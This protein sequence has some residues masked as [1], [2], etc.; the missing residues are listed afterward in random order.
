MKA[1][2]KR[3]LHTYGFAFVQYVSCALRRRDL[4]LHFLS[5]YCYTESSMH[6]NYHP[7]PFRDITHICSLCFH[8]TLPFQKCMVIVMYQYELISVSSCLC[9]AIFL[10]QLNEHFL[11]TQTFFIYPPSRYRCTKNIQN[12]SHSQASLNLDSQTLLCCESLALKAE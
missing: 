11:T 10:F 6:Y 4:L 2:L 9:Q 5:F 1:L 8:S 12:K 3:F 7:H